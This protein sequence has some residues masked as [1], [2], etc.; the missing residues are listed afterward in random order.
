MFVYKDRVKE[1]TVTTGTGTFALGG[2]E[3]PYQ[4]FSTAI[5]S[6]NK[7]SYCAVAAG[8]AWE[9]GLGVVTA[10]TPDTL[11]RLT[12]LDSS[13]SGALVSFAAGTKDVFCTVSAAGI[14]PHVGATAPAI[15]VPGRF[16][17][18]NSTVD[19]GL[20][21]CYD[22]GTTTQW[23]KVAGSGTD[24]F[25][26]ETFYSVDYTLQT[27]QT[28]S[29]NPF[30]VDGKSYLSTIPAGSSLVVSAAGVTM[31][32]GST[33]ELN[34]GL[35]APQLAEIIGK[36]RS[37]RRKFAM[38]TQIE[39]T[40]LYNGS[41][42]GFWFWGQT[43]QYPDHGLL[44]VRGRNGGGVSGV[45]NTPEG[46]LAIQRWHGAGN[47]HSKVITAT[48]YDVWCVVWHSPREA[49]VYV[50]NFGAG[51]PDIGDMVCVANVAYVDGFDAGAD[52]INVGPLKDVA[53]WS[54]Y[55]AAYSAGT[56]AVVK[57]FR[58]TSA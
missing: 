48:V 35:N 20:Y 45:A 46:S 21:I 52:S 33:P 5:G 7:C 37:R 6:G 41:P 1:T 17:F 25:A 47:I 50:G 22:N 49:A 8:G 44:I 26:V 55:W 42:G 58:I 34:F 3:V 28:V 31:T 15:A 30:Y 43:A 10:G 13:N 16:W 56:V 18:N 39:T 11:S 51:W 57:K 2:A 12:V 27:P 23:V 4:A 38:W 32:A 9:V 40:S 14:S 54:P 53:Q 29:T 24:P 19:A 36:S